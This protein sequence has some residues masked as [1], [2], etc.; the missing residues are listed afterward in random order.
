VSF[1]KCE[2]S[3]RPGVCF[4]MVDVLDNLKE[5]NKDKGW[6]M[7]SCLILILCEFCVID[8]DREKKRCVGNHRQPSRERERDTLRKIG[9][10]PSFGWL[11]ASILT[12]NVVSL[13]SISMAWIF[14]G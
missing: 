2:E 12:A 1:I 6:N 8:R 5:K 14:F 13:A 9:T 3:T 10:G 11:F 4:L 7:F